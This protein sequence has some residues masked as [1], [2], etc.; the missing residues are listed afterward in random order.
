M[1]LEDA[2]RVGIIQNDHN[3]DYTDAQRQQAHNLGIEA[4]KRVQDMRISP[5]TTAD[6]LLPG[7]TEEE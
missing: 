3:P 7:E 1:R 5:C 4:L 6:E 2:I